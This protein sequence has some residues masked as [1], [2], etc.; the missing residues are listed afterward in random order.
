MKS[1]IL[2]LPLLL[3]H[4]G[5][6]TIVR[7]DGTLIAHEGILDE[8]DGTIFEATTPQGL[9]ITRIASKPNRTR[10]ANSFIGMKKATTLGAQ[11]RDERVNANNNDASVRL[12]KEHTKQIPL[13]A[14]AEQGTIKANS[15]AA[16]SAA[17]IAKKP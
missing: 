5:A 6:V 12:E 17:E 15:D 8:A 3:C 7:P 11:F 13:N 16:N 10:V 14:A 4:C 1:L 9:K 2:L